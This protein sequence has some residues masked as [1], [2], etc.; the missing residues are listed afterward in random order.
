MKWWIGKFGYNPQQNVWVHIFACDEI[1]FSAFNQVHALFAKIRKT[2]MTLRGFAFEH[3]K[4][5]CLEGNFE[6][7][8]EDAFCQNLL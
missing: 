7:I 5:L 3:L 8:S 4:N 1:N 6:V 2:E